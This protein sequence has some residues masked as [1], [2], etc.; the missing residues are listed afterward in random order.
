VS[1][2]LLIL[3]VIA[4]ILNTI[5]SGSNA[6]LNKTLH[7]PMWSVVTVFAVA[8]ITSV[9]A[10][11]VHGERFPNIEAITKVPWWAWIGG[12]FGALYILS[13]MLAANKMGAAVFMGL[14]VTLAV[15]T[16]M[17]MDHFGFLG[18]EVHKAGI[19]RVLGGALM[20]GG[21]ALIAK[22]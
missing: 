7:S 9:A 6:T 20:V 18:F 2:A 11:L 8:L 14:T 22:Y 4:G 19:A 15:I 1:A 10:A 17:V 13:M 21:V 3:V 5:Q 16:S 12:M